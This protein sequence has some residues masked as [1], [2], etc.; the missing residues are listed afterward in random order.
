ME[1]KTVDA[2]TAARRAMS[3]RIVEDPLVKVVANFQRSVAEDTVRSVSPANPPL[4]CR[5]RQRKPGR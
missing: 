5:P 3:K 4:A 1:A 2:A